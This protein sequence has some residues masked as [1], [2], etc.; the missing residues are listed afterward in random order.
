MY[1][2]ASS[3]ASA[4]SAPVATQQRTAL[5]AV[6]VFAVAIAVLYLGLPQE[7]SGNAVNYMATA[8]QVGLHD[9]R[10]YPPHLMHV[11]A[12]SLTYNMLA[13][14]A[15]CGPTCAGLLHSMLWAGIG[16]VSIFVIAR[17]LFGLLGGLALAAAVLVSHGFWIFA[18][19]AEVYAAGVG[20]SM[21]ASCLLLTG[22]PG[23]KPTRRLIAIAL[24]WAMATMYHIVN[25]LL[26]I[27][28][29]L[30]FAVTQGRSGWW[31]WLA[32]SV[33]A[34]I[35]VAASFI[36]AYVWSQDALSLRG[37][38]TWLLEITNR[39]LTEWG[40]VENWTPFAVVQGAWNQIEALVLWPPRYAFGLSY[41]WFQAPL[42]LLAGSILAL[43]FA[44]NIAAIA[45]RREHWPERLYFVALCTVWFLVF[46]WWDPTVHKFYI[47]SAVAFL[48]LVGFFAYDGVR[49]LA[50]GRGRRI[51]A[52][53]L[54]V[55]IA[56]VGALNSF[57]IRELARSKGPF[58]AEATRLFELAP[59]ECRIYSVGQ[60]LGPLRTYF[61]RQDDY[62]ILR[63]ERE[64]YNVVT[65]VQPRD[66]NRFTNEP[67]AFVMLGWL[68]P[69]Q[70]ERTMARYMPDQR[71]EDYIAYVLDAQPAAA[72]G[73]SVNPFKIVAD[74][75]DAR[76]VLIDRSSRMA[77]GNVE[78]AV[79]PLRRAVES[80]L[81]RF[82]E[83]QQMTPRL[84]SAVLSVPRTGFET[85]YNRERLFGYSWGDEARQI[86]NRQPR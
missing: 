38:F 67:C 42:A 40:T 2:E 9:M 65:G 10:L 56:A 4:V 59:A 49:R 85:R 83:A 80:A 29:L 34:G 78:E 79:Q 28:F 64:F 3:R 70:F 77:V 24:F 69:Q 60:H 5:E 54:A 37:F 31:Q 8:G 27:P 63:L 20:A 76:Y 7:M 43:S 61:D 68:S 52:A 16:V 72:G 33:I 14:I 53:A 55:A 57:S 13:P 17:R 82:P 35:V 11:P 23:A 26:F 50:P 66:P 19:Q 22:P 25:V 86:V 18:T 39:P 15:P 73:L 21:A 51:A 44:W 75:E 41:P 84:V 48:F 12:I 32:T 47:H 45:R 81:A 74:G 62:F 46:T 36:G 6:C 71:W 1:T 30:Y 58:V